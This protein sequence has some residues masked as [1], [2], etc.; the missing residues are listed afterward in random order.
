M[1]SS[2]R[3]SVHC[4]LCNWR[5]S[6]VHEQTHCPYCGQHGLATPAEDREVDAWTLEHD[7][8]PYRGDPDG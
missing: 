4:R 2:S 1:P 5:G 7:E 8:H 3:K 6:V